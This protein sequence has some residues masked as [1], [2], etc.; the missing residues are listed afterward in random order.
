MSAHL[1]AKTSYAFL[2]PKASLASATRSRRRQ[3]RSQEFE[4]HESGLHPPPSQTHQK[5]NKP[6]H[7][8]PDPSHDRTGHHLPNMR[9]P[10]IIPSHH[11]TIPPHSLHRPPL[12]RRILFLMFGRA[13]PPPARK[14]NFP[15][16]PLPNRAP[17]FTTTATRGTLTC[18][19]GQVN[20]RNNPT[21]SL[22]GSSGPRRKNPSSRSSRQP[23]S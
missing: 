13:R 19:A 20:H 21:D 23:T 18:H 1:P 3:L 9:P 14:P 10:R 17:Q 6:P 8:Q 16:A 15:P 11:P 5:S 2:R 7:Q 12:E 4:N 22:C